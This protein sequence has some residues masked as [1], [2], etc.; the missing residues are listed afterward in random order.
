MTRIAPF[1]SHS[2]AWRLELAKPELSS[3][4]SKESVRDAATQ[5]KPSSSN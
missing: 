2:R 1:S 3:K 5:G 4:S